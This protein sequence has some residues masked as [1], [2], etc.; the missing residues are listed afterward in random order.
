ME[1]ALHWV[2]E[3]SP[4]EGWCV[5]LCLTEH[6]S[7]AQNPGCA[8]AASCPCVELEEGRVLGEPPWSPLA[9]APAP[10]HGE[11]WGGGALHG[12]RE[13]SALWGRPW[14]SCFCFCPGVSPERLVY[15]LGT[16]SV[17]G[18]TVPLEL[19]GSVLLTGVEGCLGQQH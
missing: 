5:L 19:V 10:G 17:P 8:V 16:C 3:P 2:P 11:S 7:A 18:S 6:S 12:C 14:H 13:C 1:E 4:G 15:A 9:A